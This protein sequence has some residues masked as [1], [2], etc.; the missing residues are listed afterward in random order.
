MQEPSVQSSDS[1]LGHFGV[2][3][4][5]LNNKRVWE[6]KF[7]VPCNFWEVRNTVLLWQKIKIRV[8]HFSNHLSLKHSDPLLSLCFSIL[9]Q[10]I[11]LLRSLLSIT[12]RKSINKI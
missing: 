2:I 4:E 6:E 8:F 11:F 5:T 1:K 10:G 3:T 7:Q 12:R 9:M